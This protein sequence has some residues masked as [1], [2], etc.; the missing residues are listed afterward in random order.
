MLAVLLFL[1]LYF[2][3]SSFLKMSCGN[4]FVSVTPPPPRR[5]PL[6]N[7]YTIFFPFSFFISIK[8]QVNPTLVLSL[9]AQ[10]T[11]FYWNFYQVKSNNR[12]T[13]IDRFYRELIS[14]VAKMLFLSFSFAVQ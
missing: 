14:F 6:Q 11:V 10:L 4:E 13:V 5:G 9:V 8:L 2:C 3:L 1:P 7:F 12:L